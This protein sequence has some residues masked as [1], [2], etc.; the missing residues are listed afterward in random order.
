M[1]VDELATE[2]GKVTANAQAFELITFLVLGGCL[3]LNNDLA[4]RVG[5]LLSTN[6]RLGLIEE[7]ARLN[8]SR[9]DPAGVLAWIKM[10][11]DANE[12]RNRVIHSPWHGDPETQEMLGVL[13]RKVAWEARAAEH[14]K[15]DRK[16]LKAAIDGAAKLIDIELSQ[17]G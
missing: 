13:N 2:L 10:A 14:L 8:E 7:L 11:R 16:T 5:Q 9:L 6:A 17:Q 3:G 15:K 12:A 1:K 4:I